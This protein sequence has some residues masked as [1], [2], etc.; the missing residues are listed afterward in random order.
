MLQ[1]GRVI[2]IVTSFYMYKTLHIYMLK[3]NLYILGFIIMIII[4]H[5]NTQLQIIL[6]NIQLTK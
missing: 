1:Y 6:K 5:L 3:R 4:D 2:P